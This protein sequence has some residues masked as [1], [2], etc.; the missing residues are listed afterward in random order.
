MTKSTVPDLRSRILWTTTYEFLHHITS[1]YCS[2]FLIHDMLGWKTTW[3]SAPAFENSK[4]YRI[5]WVKDWSTIHWFVNCDEYSIPQFAGWVDHDTKVERLWYVRSRTW[6]Q[7]GNYFPRSYPTQTS[8]TK[9]WGWCGQ[10]KV[11]RATKHLGIDGNEERSHRTLSSCILA[12][13][14]ARSLS[15]FHLPIISQRF[16][17]PREFWDP[18]EAL[19]DCIPSKKKKKRY[20]LF[21]SNKSNQFFENI[22]QSLQGFGWIVRLGD[23]DVTIDN[24]TE[25]K[26]NRLC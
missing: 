24:T 12:T 6:E 10:V 11:A 21:I 3:K 26:L 14:G 8:W 4:T 19:H 20:W 7:R 18:H 22:Y 16:V 1:N 13:L 5:E 25:R 23:C 2:E 15:Y 17:E 9:A